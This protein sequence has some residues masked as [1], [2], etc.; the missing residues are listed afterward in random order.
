MEYK[1]TN[2]P[3]WMRIIIHVLRMLSD[4]KLFVFIHIYNTNYQ[5]K[6]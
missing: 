4:L 1:T 2:L 5:I 3:I 6:N